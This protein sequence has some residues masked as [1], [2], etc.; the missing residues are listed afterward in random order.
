MPST[1][2]ILARRKTPKVEL[3]AQLLIARCACNRS[4]CFTWFQLME[5]SNS[6]VIREN[7]KYVVSPCGVFFPEQQAEAV[8]C[9]IWA[10]SVCFSPSQ[11][12][13]ALNVSVACGAG[14][15]LNPFP[16]CVYYLLTGIRWLVVL[17]IKFRPSRFGFRFRH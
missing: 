9:D 15:K 14:S 10:V 17:W 1:R 2:I 11:L 4:C 7:L 6:K 8:S 16:G 13:Q 12:C 5:I 3:E